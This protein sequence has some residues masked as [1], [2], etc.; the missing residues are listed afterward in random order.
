[1]RCSLRFAFLFENRTAPAIP[2]SVADVADRIDNTLLC[3]AL[4]LVDV[5]AA[6]I[7]M[8]IA[9]VTS[10]RKGLKSCFA[11]VLED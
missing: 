2:V 11:L 8:D 6:T 10:R 5:S 4:L 7:A 1:M 9:D 3:A